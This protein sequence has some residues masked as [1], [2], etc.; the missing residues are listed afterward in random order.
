MIS[1][2]SPFTAKYV[3]P[4][5][6]AETGEDGIG[7]FEEE[8]VVDGDE[9]VHLAEVEQGCPQVGGH[10]DGYIPWGDP[11]RAQQEVEDPG[12]ADTVGGYYGNNREDDC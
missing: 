4:E 5:D 6:E 10:L 12:E 3:V 8:L 1:S 9:H 2:D 7:H 11:Y